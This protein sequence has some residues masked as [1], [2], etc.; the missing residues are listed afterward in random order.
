MNATNTSQTSGG[1][2]Y[3]PQAD[4]IMDASYNP[5]ATSNYNNPYLFTGRRLDILDNGSLKLQ[6][7]RNRYYDQYTGRF[8]THDPLGYVDG[9]NLYE[10]VGSNPVA[11]AD[12]F[13]LTWYVWRN[14]WYKA[15]AVV[16]VDADT[17]K[18]LANTIGLEVNEW[19][20]WLTIEK[21]R[22][23]TTHGIIHK[24]RLTAT[25]KICSCETFKVPNVVFAHWAG[26]LGGF[27]KMWVRW[28]QDRMTLEGKGFMVDHVKDWP[29]KKFN[30]YIR[31]NTK[32][33]TL[34]GIL[35]WGHGFKWFG[36]GLLT[37]ASK[38]GDTAYYSYYGQWK[39]SYKMGLGILFACHSNLGKTHFSSNGIFWGSKGTLIPIGIPLPSGVPSVKSILEDYE[40]K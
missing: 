40:K 24:S 36:G 29:A 38:G 1:D 27:G 13:G 7:N 15:L 35:F 21:D 17:I 34:H 28:K 12:P 33:Q 4:Q 18:N 6:Y 20:K 25:T 9:M 5:R 31:D 39:P 16:N 22:I 32:A 37:S 11:N 23:N 10:Y 2:A 3:P 30:R 26:V 8:F 14:G 19:R